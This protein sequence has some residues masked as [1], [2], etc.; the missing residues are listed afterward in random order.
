MKLISSNKENMKIQIGN[1]TIGEDSPCF[2]IA[3]IGINHNNDINIAKKM[4]DAAVES[5]CDASKF[6][7]FKGKLMY[8][9]TA[10]T[11]ETDGNTINIYDVMK[12]I[13]L[14]EEWIGE[15]MEYCKKKDIVFFSSVSDI[16]SVDIMEKYGMNAYK[17]T[18]Y[19]TTNIPL[20]E[21]TA[22]KDKPIIISV[23]AAYMNEVDEAVRTIKKY[24]NKLAVLHCVTKY[25]AP[26]DCCNLNVL[27]TLKLA[28]P[29]VVWGYSDHTEDPT[30]APVA[31]VVKGAKIIEKH[32]T[33]DK[34][35]RGADQRFAVNP[36]QLKKMVNAIRETE[37]KMKNGEKIE[38]DEVVLGSSEK[39][40]TEIE[41]YVRDFAYRSI[42]ATKNIK[43]GE[44]LSRENIGVLRNGENKPGLH[45]RYYSML[46]EKNY[47]I[48]KDVEEERA[49]NWNDLI[50]S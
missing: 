15:L 29:D 41:M 22:K 18:S 23:G 5:G 43:K 27:E 19:D 46:I 11:Y 8:P 4:I 28:Y 47:K 21:Y 36:E 10:G 1:K 2:I 39:K 17:L 31:A 9:K 25:P 40:P 44:R 38:V 3:E 12:K 30:I 7:T 26:L 42:F 49:L 20:L 35:M 6:Q 32:I 48:I 34:N 45:P 24:N 33:L 14:P 16:W 13:E 37:K 50:E